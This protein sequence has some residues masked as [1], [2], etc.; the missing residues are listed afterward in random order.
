MDLEGCILPP[1]RRQPAVVAGFEANSLVRD[2][3]ELRRLL[4][5]SGE[6]HSNRRAPLGQVFGRWCKPMKSKQRL[7][8]S[9]F[10]RKDGKAAW[11]FCSKQA[12]LLGDGVGRSAGLR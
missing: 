12:R 10:V 5:V 4:L 3:V 2:D 9:A 6:G 11:F 7:E 8:C 1:R